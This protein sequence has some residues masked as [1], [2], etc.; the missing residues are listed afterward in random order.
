MTAAL[1]AI[2]QTAFVGMPAGVAASIAP[3]SQSALTFRSR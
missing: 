3:G 2:Y 1:P